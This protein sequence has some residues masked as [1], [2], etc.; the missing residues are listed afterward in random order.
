[1]TRPTRETK[2]TAP[3]APK[4]PGEPKRVR[5]AIYTRKST[6]EGLDQEFNS[7]HAQREAAEAFIASQKHDGW[8][9]LP[10]GYDDGGFSGGT[11]ERPALARLLADIEAGE[12]D[13]VVVYKVDR[14]S[15]SLLDFAR[16]ME[17]FERKGIS[18][19]SVTQQFNTASSMGRLILNVLLSFAQFER[20]MIAERTR[21]KM[22]AARRKGKWV[23]G[24]P[25]LGYDVVDGKLAVNDVEAALVRELFDLYLGHQSLLRVTEVLN[26][27]GCR[28]KSWT[29]K[30]GT[31]HGGAKWTKS[32]VQR[33]LVNPTYVGRVLYRGEEYPGEHQAI[34]DPGVFKKVQA[35][36]DRVRAESAG[37]ERNGHGFLLRGLIRCSRCS[38][39]MTSV[40]SRKDRKVYR[41]YACSAVHHQ[42][43]SACD[44]RSVPAEAIEGFVVGKIRGMVHSPELLQRLPERLEA[45]WRK[46]VPAL[47]EERQR[48]THD[49]ERC[50]AEAKNLLST[51]ATQGRGDGRFVGERLGE[52]EQQAQ[53]LEA[54]LAEVGGRLKALDQ[55]A[56]DKAMVASILKMFDPV[57]D[58]LIPSE[59]AR[60]VHLLIEGITYDGLGGELEMKLS[61]A[62]RALIGA[63]EG[64]KEAA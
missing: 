12:V 19:V 58:R 42:G 31:K 48:L 59:R 38:S 25:A 29:T 4:Q 64:S 32:A 7:L 39:A 53:Q 33:L 26:G 24:T 54:R 45:E 47:S 62:G 50:R 28:M 34:V 3:R 43:T 18:F 41:Y 51:L 56:A 14:L 10:T 16:M 37:A 5:C 49:L 2:F 13:V 22:G 9:L 30:K 46:E 36:L 60:V 44:V 40:S 17:L 6:E 20:E 52:L 21:D 57:W 61:P 11:M 27:R 55:P 35:R 15:R 23:G 63:R 8:E 1:M